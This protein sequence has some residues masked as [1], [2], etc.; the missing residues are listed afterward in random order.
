M[1]NRNFSLGTAPNNTTGGTN[2]GQVGLG[3][4]IAGTQ[5]NFNNGAIGSTGVMTDLAVEGDGFFI[6]EK[7]AERFYSRSGAFQ[8]N[9]NNDLVTI[10]GGRVMGLCR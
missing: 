2:P 7:G 3:V 8:L 6:V 9:A 5:R 4:K 10:G 1:F